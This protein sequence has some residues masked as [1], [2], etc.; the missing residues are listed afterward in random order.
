MKTVHDIIIVGGGPGGI[1]SAVES[2]ILGIEGV[3]LFEKGENHSTTI[4]KFYKD[5][6]RVDRDYK[7]QSVDLAGNIY[8]IDG[9]K[10]STLD[11]FDAMLKNHSIEARFN[12]EIDRIVKEG[13]VFAIYT[14]G[15]DV[16]LARYV[17]ISIGKMGQPNKPSYELP[18]TIK[19]RINFNVNNA[20]EG[21]SILVVGGGNSA[22]EYAYFLI[23]LCK[24]TLNYRKMEF[25]R[26]NPINQEL[27]E[28]A[29]S[30]NR[31]TAKMGIDIVKVE[32]FNGLVHVFF[33]DGSEEVFDR[34]IFAIGG[35]APIDFLKRCGIEVDDHGV[36]ITDEEHQ[37]SV[38]GIYIAGDI[39][40][41]SGG[42]IATALNNGFTIVQSIEKRLK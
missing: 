21:E 23:D 30:N 29:I 19:S 10:E 28:Q 16:E 11:L 5:M 20:Q 35:M 15:G 17:V 32:D 8:F 25:S 4:R 40:F 36:P 7:G 42:S 14:T 9:T 1:A 22:V 13:D 31:L 26:I 37:S 34:I 27:I 2:M 33:T 3:V 39:L 6:K 38:D 24:V 12:T 41:K 18:G